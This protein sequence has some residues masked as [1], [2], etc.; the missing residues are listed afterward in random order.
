VTT[1]ITRI[2][3]KTDS[4]IT[5]ALSTLQSHKKEWATL[6]VQQ[7]HDM[8]LTLRSSLRENLDRWVRLATEGKLLDPDSPWVGEIWSGGPWAI[9]MGISSL[10]RSTKALANGGV[11]QPEKLWTRPNG[12]LVGEVYP[13]DIYDRLLINDLRMEV[14]MQPGVTRENLAEYTAGFYKQ[15]DPAG[16]VCLLLGAGNIN[17]IPALD[18]LH[19]LYVK[20]RVV[21]LKM[22]PVN[23]YM[24]PI[25]EDVFRCYID[26]GYLRLLYGGARF[27]ATLVERPE[28]E[29]IHVTGSVKTF[30]QI[31]FGPGPEGQQRKARGERVLAK[32]ITSELGGVGPLIVVPGP[33][34]DNDIAFQAENILTIKLHN[35]GHNCVSSQ[36]LI[37]PEKWERTPQLIEA[38]R[39]GM[40]DLPPRTAYY[41]ESAERQQEFVSRYPRAEQFNSKIPRTLLAGVNPEIEDQFCFQAEIFGPV[42]AQLSLPGDSAEEYLDNAV[43]FAN[44]RLQ[45]TL[46]VTLIVHPKTLKEM[47]PAFEEAIANLHYGTVGINLWCA[48]G[49]LIPQAVWGGYPGAVDTDIQSGQ[50]YVHNSLM[51]DKAERTV[52]RGSFYPFPRAWLHGDFHIAPKPA[53]FVTNKTAATTIRRVCYLAIDR[54]ARHLPGIFASALRG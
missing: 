37:T 30:E 27:G 22:N 17:A 4:E 24:G 33:W 2:E 36:V 14:W 52:V 31:V 21:L 40:R 46:G 5:E 49:F 43:R 9:A 8:L 20:G 10:L 41:P 53:W 32:S 45:G 35:A 19:L 44:E 54:H 16:E 28:V 34:D 29:S 26:A 48:G 25:F 3:T 18:I 6:P 51:F 47:G 50:G 7:K 1:T 38:V 11:P 39:L 23:D 42:L 12:Q 13:V 15:I